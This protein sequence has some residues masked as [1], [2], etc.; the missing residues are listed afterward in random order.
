M[1]PKLKKPMFIGSV[2][3]RVIAKFMAA[4]EFS[5]IRPRMFNSAILAAFMRAI[6]AFQPQLGGMANTAS[7]MSEPA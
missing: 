7:L 1:L 5:L 3:L 6:L 2:S 4:A